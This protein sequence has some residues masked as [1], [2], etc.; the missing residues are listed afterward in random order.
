MIRTAISAR[1]AAM[2]RLNGVGDFRGDSS[3]S[4]TSQSVQGSVEAATEECTCDNEEMIRCRRGT[5]ARGIRCSATAVPN[6]MFNNMM[7]MTEEIVP[8]RSS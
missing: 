8:R 2:I 7:C 4:F 3:K 1:L 5:A 6:K